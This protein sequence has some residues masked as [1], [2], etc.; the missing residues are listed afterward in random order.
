MTTLAEGIAYARRQAHDAVGAKADIDL[1]GAVNDAIGMIARDRQWAWYQTLSSI[2]LQAAYTTGTITLTA[3]DATVTL[4]GGTWPAWTVYGKI[5]YD[6]KWITIATRTDDTGI[7]LT[8]AWAEA[9]VSGVPLILYR[10]EYALPTDCG[11]FGKLFP[12]TGWVWG[13]EPV[14]FVDILQAY[15]GYSGGQQYPQMWALYKDKIIVWPYP[16]ASTQVNLLY[17]RLPAVLS[18]TTAALD[19]DPT[20]LDLLYRAIDHQLTYR[21]GNV[22]AGD[23]GTTKAMYADALARAVKNEKQPMVRGNWFSGGSREI[24]PRLVHL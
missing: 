2:T 18:D 24:P 11:R 21:F 15:N 10:D 1:T 16:T 5:L 17:Y 6:G 19:W 12:G 8:N 9:T 22:V 23:A 13:G 4:A 3:G 14:G 7:E 20:Q